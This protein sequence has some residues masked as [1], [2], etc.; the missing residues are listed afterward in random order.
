VEIYNPSILRQVIRD[1]LPKLAGIEY[2]KGHGGSVSK[3]EALAF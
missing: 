2:S 1:A 3:I